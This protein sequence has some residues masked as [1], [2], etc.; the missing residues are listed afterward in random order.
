[1]DS[2][3]RAEMNEYYSALLQKHGPKLASLKFT[4][5]AQ[6]ID[7]FRLLTSIESMMQSDSVLDVGCGLGHLCSYL[8]KMGWMGSYTGVDINS[9][10]IKWSKERLPQE[11]FFCGDILLDE[12]PES[13]DYV[14]CGATLQHRPKFEDSRNYLEKMINKMFGL[15]KKGLAFDVFSNRV[16]FEDPMNL[17]IGPDDLLNY[18]YTLTRRVSLM[19]HYRPYE[20]MIYMYK[21]DEKISGNVYETWSAPT[22]TIL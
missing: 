17:Y 10:M 4:C 2:K 21:G 3:S 16:D 1:M 20:M 9:D 19:S 15:T 22:P 6:Q 12:L 18:C 8:R 7:R 14:F 13:Y 11:I 5:E